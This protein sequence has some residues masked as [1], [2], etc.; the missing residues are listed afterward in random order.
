MEVHGAADCPAGMDL[1]ELPGGLYA[2]FTHKG[3]ASDAAATY[4]YIFREWLPVAD[5][6]LDQRPHLA[7]MGEK[8][9]HQD[10]TSEENIWI[11][12]RSRL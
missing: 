4:N 7:V 8:Y 12:V 6:M 3:P 11:P 2:I 10:D 5:Y 9:K 1:L